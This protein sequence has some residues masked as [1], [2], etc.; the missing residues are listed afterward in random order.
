MYGR[1]RDGAN[2]YNEE[3]VEASKVYAL[4]DIKRSMQQIVVLFE[5][6]LKTLEVKKNDR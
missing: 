5:Q 1:F 3:E 4:E 6:I 2:R